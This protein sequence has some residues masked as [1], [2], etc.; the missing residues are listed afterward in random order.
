MLRMEDK[1]QNNERRAL[2][3]RLMNLELYR[4]IPGSL[5]NFKEQN[6]RKGKA[7]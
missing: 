3:L 2:N 7:L 1:S 6:Y 4:D 5:K